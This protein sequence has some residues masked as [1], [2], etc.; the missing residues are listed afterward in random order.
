MKQKYWLFNVLFL[1][2]FANAI[3][4]EVNPSA[5]PKIYVSTHR[6]IDYYH[7]KYTLT[8]D[9]VELTLPTYHKYGPSEYFFEYGN[10]QLFIPKEKFP[11]SAPN[12][13]THI[14]LRMPMTMGDVFAKRYYT[15]EQERYIAEKRAVYD[16]IKQIK[17]SGRGEL[18]VVVELNPY[19]KVKQEEPLE[20][21]LE[22][23]NVFFRDA[24]GQYIDY[25]G[26]LKWTIPRIN[27]KLFKRLEKK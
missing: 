1:L 15:S 5:K 8:P 27:K 4:S 11:I 16:K 21:E 19:V 18:E 23:C 10:F 2:F 17:E 12:C 14:I 7:M 13:N 3:A 6:G 20:V 26:P 24:Y 22:W 25:V 9:N